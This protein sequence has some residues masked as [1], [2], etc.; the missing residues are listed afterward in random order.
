MH[1]LENE[2]QGAFDHLSAEV[3]T[4]KE[5]IGTLSKVVDGELAMMREELKA[6]REE[7]RGTV[8]DA[9]TEAD[10]AAQKVADASRSSQAL[11][12]LS[13]GQLKENLGRVENELREARNQHGELAAWHSGAV[14]RLDATAEAAKAETVRGI[15]ALS[16][17]VTKTEELGSE[18]KAELDQRLVREHHGLMAWADE[19]RGELNGLRVDVDAARGMADDAVSSAEQLTAG[20]RSTSAAL[21]EVDAEGKRHLSAINLLVSNADASSSQARQAEEQ[22]GSRLTGLEQQVQAAGAAHALLASSNEVEQNQLRESLKHLEG[23][24]TAL[25]DE[26]SA[27]KASAGRQAE[28]LKSAESD[29]S[30][31]RRDGAEAAAGARKLTAGLK[32]V[33][34]KQKQGEQKLRKNLD[35]IE[36]RH[37]AYDQAFSSFAEALK[38]AN[39]LAKGLA[40]AAAAL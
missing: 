8:H 37:E 26:L 38:L 9:R 1:R 21:A 12:E 28:R 23:A 40:R 27:T 19:A 2:S 31:L 16:E 29:I 20:A 39:P 6:I 4:L 34:D 15:D 14:A 13:V 36:V 17:R 35:S 11:V 3:G 5:A 32:D 10:A 7:M 24:S 30:G 25:R 22:L 33:V 18:I